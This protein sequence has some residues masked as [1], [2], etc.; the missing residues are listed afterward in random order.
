MLLLFL[1]FTKQPGNIAGL[2]NLGEI[3]LRLYFCGS[4]PLSWSR[5]GFCRKVLADPFSFIFL[6][7]A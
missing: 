3:D 1:S 7:R 6:K 4:R 5:A 2:G